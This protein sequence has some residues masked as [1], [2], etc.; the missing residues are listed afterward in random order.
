[1]DE[2]L[3]RP[4]KRRRHRY[5]N[6]CRSDWKRFCYRLFAQLFCG[7][8]GRL[9]HDRIFRGGNPLWTNFYS[10]PGNRNDRP[11]A[12][13]ADCDGKVFVTGYATLSNGAPIYAT[14]A[15]STAGRSLWTN[16]YTASGIQPFAAATA[17]AVDAAGHL[18][19]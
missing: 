7:N 9:R 10:G 4:R 19:V 2:L 12:I 16:T 14:L 5:G 3:Q 18:F 1:M 15:Y 8:I 11:A 13:A 6:H 17:L